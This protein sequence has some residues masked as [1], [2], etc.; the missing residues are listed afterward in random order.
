MMQ[1]R[2]LIVDV[3][4]SFRERR[5]PRIN[6]TDMA[7]VLAADPEDFPAEQSALSSERFSL[8]PEWLQAHQEASV[9]DLEKIHAALRYQRTMEPKLY[10]AID[11]LLIEV[12]NLRN[13]AIIKR[14]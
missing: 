2:T 13:T 7:R 5:F 11:Q 3:A 12:E 9:Y 8:L 6:A 1:Q 10:P 14:V 4:Y